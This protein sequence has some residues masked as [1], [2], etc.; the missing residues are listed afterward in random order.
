M[1]G[2]T[3]IPFLYVYIY[4]HYT[5]ANIYLFYDNLLYMIDYMNYLSLPL[6]GSMMF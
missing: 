3:W 6:S 1:S 2:I 4:I 5:F